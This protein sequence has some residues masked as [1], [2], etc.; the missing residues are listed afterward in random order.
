MV[1]SEK[2]GPI[3][4][5]GQ[6]AVPKPGP[7]GRRK[8][9]PPARRLQPGV[10][11]DVPQNDD[12]PPSTEERGFRGQVYSAPRELARRGLVGGGRASRRRGD[13]TVHESESVMPRDRL[14]PG[15]EP[16]PVQSLVE[17]RS[18]RV[19][20]EHAT[21]PVRTVGRRREADND[22]PRT[23]VAPTRH[24][25]AP[26]RPP[27]EFRLPRSG[28]T[29]AVRAQPRAALAR[30]NG[31]RHGGER[32]KPRV[33]WSGRE[34]RCVHRSGDFMGK[35]RA[36][37]MRVRGAHTHRSRLARFTLGFSQRRRESASPGCSAL[38]LPPDS[39]SCEAMLVR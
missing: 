34:L 11:R 9:V 5:P 10:V 36:R 8:R 15:G 28:H 16:E 1:R 30:F 3:W 18:A 23:H 26:V 25:F 24:G 7:V 37:P 31:T 22:E 20:G 32:A 27:R 19:P 35:N 13:V 2:G 4:E 21:G 12:H 6:D 17:P 38:L 29:L 14:R 33:G 39:G